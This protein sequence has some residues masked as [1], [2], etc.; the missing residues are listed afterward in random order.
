MPKTKKEKAAVKKSAPKKTHAAHKAKKPKIAK[1]IK[2]APKAKATALKKK[3]IIS[4]ADITPKAPLDVLPISPV[5]EKPLAPKIP[6]KE[7]IIPQKKEERHHEVIPKEEKPQIVKEQKP[8]ELKVDKH[9]L[10]AERHHPKEEKQAVVEEKVKPPLEA[11]PVVELRELELDLPIT[12]KDLSVKLQEKSSI[13]IKNLM[14]QGVMAGLNQSL[15]EETVT[16]ICQ[17]YGFQIRKAPEKEELF[18]R[19]HQEEDFPQD[20]K[21]RPPIVTFMGHVDH[22]K[23]SLLDAIR[24][25][26]VA[27]AEHGG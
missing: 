11:K 2:A 18:L 8:Q 20:L 12:V 5:V 27:E 23:T 24:K 25:T 1:K 4:T 13:L 16:K 9:H 15:N 10:K 22:G 3:K 6:L 17:K 7:K 19:I 21:P 14:Q 26:K